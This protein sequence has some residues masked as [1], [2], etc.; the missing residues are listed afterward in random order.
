MNSQ[1]MIKY[2]MSEFESL[3]HYVSTRS[4][5]NQS[6]LIYLTEMS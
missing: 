3:V 5:I 4:T 6:N 1:D 2:E